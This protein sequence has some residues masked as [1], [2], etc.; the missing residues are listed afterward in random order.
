[1]VQYFDALLIQGQGLTKD[2]FQELSLDTIDSWPVNV[3]FYLL[4]YPLPIFSNMS[5]CVD[6][7]QGNF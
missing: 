7:M 2:V 5:L 6:K 3:P 4:M 1:M